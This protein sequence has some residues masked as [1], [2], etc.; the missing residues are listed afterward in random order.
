MKFLD[1]LQLALRNLRES[2]LRVALTMAGVIIG[3][4]VIISMV[5]FGL[6]LQRDA[7]S[8]F[9][10]LDGLSEIHVFGRTVFNLAAG[11]EK[12]ARTVQTTAAPAG[13][14]VPDYVP[15]RAL[16]DRALE[17]IAQIPGVVYV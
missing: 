17:E 10:D 2:K 8:R 6:G 15:E 7:L 9:Q 11:Q 4:G 3:V 14:F 16:D 1:I 13:D 5:S 12:G